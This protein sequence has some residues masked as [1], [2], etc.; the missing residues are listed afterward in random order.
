M[1]FYP[2]AVVT[3]FEDLPKVYSPNG[4]IF[5]FK[6]SDFIKKKILVFKNFHPFIMDDI[7]S[8]DIDYK[9][10]YLIAKSL[11]KKI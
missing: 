8:I 10:D 11:L 2:N 7:S 6:V 4:G 1:P 3:N 5:I 9:G